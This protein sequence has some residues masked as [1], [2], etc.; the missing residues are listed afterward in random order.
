MTILLGRMEEHAATLLA[1]FEGSA[2]GHQGEKGARREDHFREFLR[3][4]LPS[5]LGVASGEIVDCAGSRSPAM[6]IIIYD[7]SETPLLDHGD[8]GM[9]AVVPVEGVYAVVEVA[10]SLTTRKLREDAAKI[11]AA[12]AL[13]KDRRAVYSGVSLAYRVYGKRWELFPMAGF[14]FAFRTPVRRGG[15]LAHALDVAEAHLP[16]ERHVDAVCVLEEGGV[17][18]NE[19]AETQP[20]GTAIVT[21]SGR[22]GPD[23]SRS[24]HATDGGDALM[25]F[26]TFCLIPLLQ[27]QTPAINLNPYASP[28]VALPPPETGARKV[29]GEAV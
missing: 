4:V 18:L 11:H 22:P 3:A 16:V 23:T 19:A 15:T 14:I 12:K 10:S 8:A 2:R 5:R 17:I 26:Y 21:H 9:H 13:T 27:G 20:D 25:A 28:T 24:I 6:D 7:A 29:V 1:R